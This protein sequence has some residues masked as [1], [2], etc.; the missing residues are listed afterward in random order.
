MTETVAAMVVAKPDEEAEDTD[1]GEE[2]E[3]AKPE[4]PTT[5]E[6]GDPSDTAS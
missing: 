5:S 1:R 4:T 2:A 3:A 6:E